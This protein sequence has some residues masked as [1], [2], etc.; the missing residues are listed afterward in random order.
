MS[1]RGTL[2]QGPRLPGIMLREAQPQT[3][4][5]QLFK[6]HFY[7]LLKSLQNVTVGGNWAE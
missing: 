1:N 4:A 2:A 6:I 3:K 7:P 5:W